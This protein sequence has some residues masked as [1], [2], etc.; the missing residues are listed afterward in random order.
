MAVSANS[1]SLEFKESEID[2]WEEQLTQCASWLQHKA[3]PDHILR[4]ALNR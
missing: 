2:Q 4:G 1:P 3:V